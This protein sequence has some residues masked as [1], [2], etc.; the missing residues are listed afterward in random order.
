M[1]G[2]LLFPKW[3]C[4]NISDYIGHVDKNV[5]YTKMIFRCFSIWKSINALQWYMPLML[6]KY[7]FFIFYGYKSIQERS[8][9]SSWGQD[10][11]E[12][13][14]PILIVTLR[15]YI[16]FRPP[17]ISWRDHTTLIFSL[18]AQFW[19]VTNQDWCT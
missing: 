9:F 3:Q 12:Q 18:W 13:P 2:L 7:L 5:S 8:F 15:P 4:E 14:L 1:Y 11:L 6:W 17:Q 10:M 19:E 16:V